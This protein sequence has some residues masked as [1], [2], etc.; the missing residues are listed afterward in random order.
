MTPVTLDTHLREKAEWY[1]L[2]N[3]PEIQEFIDDHKKEIEP[4]VESYHWMKFNRK[5]F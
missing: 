3:Y 1:V 4:T 2:Q 5:N